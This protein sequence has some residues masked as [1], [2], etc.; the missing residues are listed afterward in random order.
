MFK[1][2]FKNIP[3]SAL[4]ESQFI[5]LL[6]FKMSL[7]ELQGTCRELCKRAQRGLFAGLK[8]GYG[9]N[10]S[11]SV[12]QYIIIYLIYSTRRTFKPNVFRKRLFS[13]ALD[14]WV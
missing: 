5:I 8:T 11:H 12:R 4:L 9:N 10:V 3:R 14:H 2:I 6:I 13:S 1:T 7:T